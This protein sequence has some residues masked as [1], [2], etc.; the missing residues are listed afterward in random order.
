MIKLIDIALIL[1]IYMPPT[2]AQTLLIK[3][4]IIIGVTHIGV[5]PN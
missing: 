1:P 4:L 2:M 5:G 3:L